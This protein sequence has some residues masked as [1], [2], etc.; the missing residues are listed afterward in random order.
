M[1]AL[2]CDTGLYK[3]CKFLRQNSRCPCSH[4]S[5]SRWSSKWFSFGFEVYTYVSLPL[6]LSPSKSMVIHIQ[7]A[8][9]T[10]P[11]N[12]ISTQRGSSQVGLIGLCYAKQAQCNRN[13]IPRKADEWLQ[14]HFT[15]CSKFSTKLSH[16]KCSLLCFSPV[17]TLLFQYETVCSLQWLKCQ[18][19]VFSLSE[20]SKDVNILRNHSFPICADSSPANASYMSPL[21]SHTSALDPRRGS[22]R[23]D[24]LLLKCLKGWGEVGTLI[25]FFFFSKCSEYTGRH[26]G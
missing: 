10:I 11:I 8:L 7:L 13:S 20:M 17:D 24:N 21:G 23:R 3:R 1:Y 14:K 18:C 2:C 9:A 25:R 15:A 26:L 4:L 6:L 16:G 12:C 22:G 5:V 19:L